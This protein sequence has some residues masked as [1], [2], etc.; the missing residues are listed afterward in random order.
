MRAGG[1][2]PLPSSRNPDKPVSSIKQCSSL[3]RRR[4]RG[5]QKE[6]FGHSKGG[7]TTRIHLIAN[8]HGLPV[9]AKITGEEV[10]DFKGFDILVD[11]DLPKAKV[12]SG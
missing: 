12:F 11:T 1:V 6:G 7:F 3:G 8:A 9:W 4:K 10:S 2:T 5:T